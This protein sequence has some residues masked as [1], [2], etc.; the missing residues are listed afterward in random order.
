MHISGHVT[1]GNDSCNICRNKIAGNPQYYVAGTHMYTWVKRDNVE[2]SLLSK[3]TTQQ[4]SSNRPFGIPTRS[5]VHHGVSPLCKGR[6]LPQFRLI[7]LFT[8]EYLPGPFKCLGYFLFSGM[9]PLLYSEREA[10]ARGLG[11]KRAASHISYHKTSSYKNPLLHRE[12][13]YYTLTFHMV[14]YVSKRS[15]CFDTKSIRQRSGF[16][17]NLKLFR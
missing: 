10:T 5:R 11:W 7:N 15:D 16:D 4:I 17:T 14:S 12:Y 3:E 8:V 2:Q 9:R 1:P 6:P 13:V